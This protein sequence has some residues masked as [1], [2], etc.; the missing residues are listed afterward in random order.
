MQ[1][2]ELGSGG[3]SDHTD[4]ETSLDNHCKHS[5]MPASLPILIVGNR[6]SR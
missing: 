5:V 4:S 1:G 2:D 3:D 6:A